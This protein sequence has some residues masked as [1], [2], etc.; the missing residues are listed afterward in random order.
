MVRAF[1][2][3]WVALS[4]TFAITAAL[5]DGMELHGGVIGSLWV[6]LLFGLVNAILG[7][8]LRILTFPLT[9]LTLGLF[10]VVVNAFLL[11]ITDRLSSDLSIDAF[12][13]TAILAAI[14]L[15]VVGA[16]VDLILR[17]LARS[18]DG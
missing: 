18:D 1:L 14:V 13:W 6:S 12:F 2:V 17:P 3:R 8:I 10:G 15:A 5:L 9:V 7:T 4:I 11:E 16:V